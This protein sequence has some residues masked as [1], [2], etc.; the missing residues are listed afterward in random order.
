MNTS[1]LYVQSLKYVIVVINNNNVDIMASIMLIY[2]WLKF[3]DILL[4][5]ALFWDVTQRRVVIV[6]RRFGK[7]YRSHLPGSR[8][9]RI[10]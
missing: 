2:S 3:T 8:N 9:P 5:S 10:S 6:Y 4:R 1:I 7:T